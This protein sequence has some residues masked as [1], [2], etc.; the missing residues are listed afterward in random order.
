MGKERSALSGQLLAKKIKNQI[1][2][3]IQIA[4]ILQGNKLFLI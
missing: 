4:K 3:M 1:E 2:K